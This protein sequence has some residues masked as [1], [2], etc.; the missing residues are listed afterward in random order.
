MT[1]KYCLDL[2][3]LIS[4]PLPQDEVPLLL[5]HKSIKKI[6]TFWEFLIKNTF[7]KF[8]LLQP[9]VIHNNKYVSCILVK[10]IP[11][12]QRLLYVFLSVSASMLTYICKIY[13]VALHH[14]T[15][16]TIYTASARPPPFCRLHRTLC[17]PLSHTWRLVLSPTCSANP[18]SPPVGR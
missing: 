12:S 14:C 10:F 18:R 3:L 16:S 7:F 17:G 2:L 8:Y 9:F 13:I 4:N 6:S 5:P 1:L 15:P 11:L